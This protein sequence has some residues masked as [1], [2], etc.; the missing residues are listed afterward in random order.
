MSNQVNMKNNG[1]CFAHFKRACT[2]EN[3]SQGE[4]ETARVMFSDLVEGGVPICQ[5]CGEE[6]EFVGVEIVPQKPDKK[7]K[8]RKKPHLL[9]CRYLTPDE[10]AAE[11]AKIAMFKD[12]GTNG[13]D[14]QNYSDTQDRKSYTP[15]NK[16]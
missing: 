13:Q 8:A 5:E 2:D 10:I 12:D 4:P 7:G 14:R 1:L 9:S 16:E 3:C 11:M 6:M 15:D